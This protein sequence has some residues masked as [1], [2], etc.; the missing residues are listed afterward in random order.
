M[1]FGIAVKGFILDKNRL[2]TVRRRDDD[3]HNPG[4]WDFPGGRLE[5][6]ENPFEGLKREIMEETGLQV[7]IKNPLRVHH[8]TRQ[9]G[10]VITMIVFLC[11]R[12]SGEVRL[13]REH[14]EY[15]WV[16]PE[17]SKEFLVKEFW[18]DVDIYMAHFRT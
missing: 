17:K 7:A 18:G 10:Q 3:V 11:E 8:F 9:D 6:G 2:L 14:T 15:K 13:S 4:T 1:L 12:L 16:E 5:P